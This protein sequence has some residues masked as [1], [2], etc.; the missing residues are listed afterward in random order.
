MAETKEK[1]K[2]NLDR[3]LLELQKSVR[4]LEKNA[5]S[6]SNSKFSYQYLSG[7][8][9]LGVVRPKMDELGLRLTQEVDLEHSTFTGPNAIIAWTFTWI[10]V[11]SGERQPHKWLAVG[12][13]SPLDKAMGSAATYAER[14]FL[15]KQLHLST[16][17]DDT[18]A[19]KD[20]DFS[21]K[22]QGA[23]QP[24]GSSALPR[25]VAGCNPNQFVNMAKKAASEGD[26]YYNKCISFL[27]TNGSTGEGIEAF[28]F[29]VNQIKAESQAS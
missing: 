10:D 4:G 13:N 3:K 2:M 17:A 5:N 16:D 28:K 23:Q 21:P 12:S 25:G 8:K 11:E 15:M 7:G 20:E 29:L 22:P 18:D 24:Q 26:D 6:G 9:L 1:T 14:Y 27:E 19:L